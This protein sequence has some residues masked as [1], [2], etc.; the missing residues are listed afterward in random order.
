MAVKNPSPTMLRELESVAALLA[1]TAGEHITAAPLDRIDV[2]FKKSRPG[3]AQDLD[4]VSS[5]DEEDERLIRDSLAARF[6]SHAILGEE[7]VESP[8]SE[9]APYVWVIDPIDGTTN[10]LNGLP[11]YGCSVAVLYRHFPVA[12]AVWCATT[13]TRSPGVYHAHHDGALSFNGAPFARRAV[14]CRGVASEP[15]TTPRYAAFFETRVLASAAL[16][17][18]FAAAGILQLAYISAPAIWDIAAGITLARAGGCRIVTKRDHVWIPFTSFT[19]LNAPTR[20]TALRAWRQPVLIGDPRA[21]DRE[22]ALGTG[23]E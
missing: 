19:P 22:A 13:H 10:Y 23:I 4:P 14:R 8:Q 9:G 5:D 18:A 16:E 12:G 7:E 2:R 17:C 21:V 3:P 6:P 1:Q 11:L 15:G 20:L